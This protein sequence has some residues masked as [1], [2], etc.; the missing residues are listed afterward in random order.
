[1]TQRRKKWIFN[2]LRMLICITA[3][4]LATRAVTLD[5]H[6]YL[7]GSDEP[8]VGTV[9]TTED[10]LTIILAGGKE[11]VLGPGDTGRNHAR[12]VYGLKTVWRQSSRELLL[13]GLLVVMPVP[14]LQGA[15]LNV[16]LRSNGIRLGLWT[17][18]K[19]LFA[20]NFANFV[21]PIGSTAGDVVKGYW[22]TLHTD[23]K[24]TAVT[25]MV[26]DR[27]VGLLGL[28]LVVGAI[29][30]LSPRD[31]VLAPF[32][33]YTL[34]IVA[35]GALGAVAYFS[36]RLWLRRVPDALL[37]RVP[38]MELIR[39][40]DQTTRTLAG[41]PRIWLLALAITLVLQGICVVSC[42]I[43]AAAIGLDVRLGNMVDFYAFFSTGCMIQ[44]LP[45]PPQGL[46]TVEL[47]YSLFFA[48]F[49]S[50]AQI[51]CM[52]LGNR[53]IAFAAALPGLLIWVMGAH[54]PQG[55]AAPLGKHV[56]VGTGAKPA[57][58]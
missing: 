8:L 13:L 12:I 23:E 5:D 45:G 43:V 42:I 6:V 56:S 50:P 18:I 9:V 52:A 29:S 47:A 31:S 3:L 36:S 33:F 19:L 35:V 24:T 44:A 21:V 58:A 40:V 16:L 49:G 32:R 54:R 25:T 26:L 30:T 10:H 53:V 17:N 46:G 14:V 7:V 41:R 2:V 39:Q 15:R 48:A 55:V 27:I 57:T 11:Q 4:W 37:E 34:G 51:M 1:M 20:G 38:A 28:V 22:I